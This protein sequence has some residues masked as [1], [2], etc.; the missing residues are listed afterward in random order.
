MNPDAR[1]VP[2]ALAS[3]IRFLDDHPDV[4]MVQGLIRTRYGRLE[5]SQGVELQV[6]HL[7]G[8]ALGLRRFLSVPLVRRLARRSARLRDHVDREPVGA[9]DVAS[10]AATAVLVR[11]IAFESVDGFD[12]AFFL[13]G[14]DLD[15]CRRLRHRGW[16]LVALPCEWAGHAS[17]AS[18]ASWSERELHWWAGTMLFA[19]RWWPLPSLAGGWVAAAV[20]SARLVA[21]RPTHGPVVARLL[22]VDPIRCRRRLRRG[23]VTG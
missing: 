1:M 2:G 23:A 19:A 9:V 8:R 15:L 16:R 4:A 3:G 18:S 6:V 20:T 22:L 11:R 14:E 21:R 17:G 12:A 7:V 5:R 13:Y 10:L